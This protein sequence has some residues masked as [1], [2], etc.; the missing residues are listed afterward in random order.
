MNERMKRMKIYAA[1]GRSTGRYYNNPSPRNYTASR[2]S[3]ID[4]LENLKTISEP[5]AY[6]QAEDDIKRKIRYSISE[7]ENLINKLEEYIAILEDANRS[8]ISNPQA[9]IDQL[10]GHTWVSESTKILTST[11]DEDW[12]GKEVEEFVKRNEA[13]IVSRLNDTTDLWGAEFVDACI[14]EMLENLDIAGIDYPD[15]VESYLFDV[16]EGYGQE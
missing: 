13:S 14:D 2:Q 5:R 1:S 6:K 4:S 8:K 12:P 16:F 15:D 7:S 3:I 9:I 11:D 10:K